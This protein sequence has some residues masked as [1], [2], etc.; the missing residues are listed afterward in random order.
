MASS[1]QL[2]PFTMDT[3]QLE[4]ASTYWGE[5]T[6]S[7]D[8]DVAKKAVNISNK[9]QQLKEIIDEYQN[10]PWVELQE[11]LSDM[12]IDAPNKNIFLSSVRKIVESAKGRK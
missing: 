5:Q 6:Q 11:A 3:S 2:Q 4:A 7:E 9:I 10:K 8:I 1:D 12:G